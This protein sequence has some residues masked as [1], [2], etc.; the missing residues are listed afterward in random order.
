MKVSDFITKTQIRTYSGDSKAVS[1]E[2]RSRSADGTASADSGDKVQISERSREVVRARELVDAG[3]NGSI[4]KPRRFRRGL[5]VDAAA[6]FRAVLAGK[7]HFFR[8]GC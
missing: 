8:M 4:Y 7:R 6:C 2:G 1:G 5:C 3:R